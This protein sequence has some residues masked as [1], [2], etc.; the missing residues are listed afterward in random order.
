M[1]ITKKLARVPD[2]VKNM[3]EALDLAK[4]LVLKAATTIQ[5]FGVKVHARKPRAI[6]VF[7][8]AVS[9]EAADELDQI[10]DGLFKQYCRPPVR[11]DQVRGD[12]PPAMN[13]APE[14]KQRRTEV[15]RST[16]A[17][18]DIQNTGTRRRSA[19]PAVAPP[20]AD[21]LET[22]SPTGAG[23]RDDGDLE[24]LLSDQGSLRRPR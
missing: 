14:P 6:V 23:D 10:I 8:K 15:R 20:P 3:G 17:P 9:D 2:S 18:R 19:P 5:P 11:A 12:A 1:A 22:Y 4:A 21:A 24:D 13:R 16:A 7:C